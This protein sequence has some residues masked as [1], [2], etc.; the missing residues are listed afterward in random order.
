MKEID[1][2]RF[3]NKTLLAKTCIAFSSYM[4]HVLFV[5]I[6][7]LC[8]Y[9]NHTQNTENCLYV[10]KV[11]ISYLSGTPGGLYTVVGLNAA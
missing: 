11:T 3:S 9:T 1:P 2:R 6:I 10:E 4:R 8:I 5:F 7:K